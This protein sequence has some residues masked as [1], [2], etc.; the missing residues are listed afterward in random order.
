LLRE[1]KKSGLQFEMEA[2]GGKQSEKLDGLSFVISGV[3]EQHSRE[4]I[5][6]LILRN[7]GTNSGSISSKT[8]YVVAGQNM[9]PSKYQKA[10]KLN[11]P[12][13][14]EE[15]FLSMLAG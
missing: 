7:G 10:Q 11:V 6:A 12:I 8:D 15:D 14:S 1:L 3:F 2:G 9:G 5:K 4:E 13:L